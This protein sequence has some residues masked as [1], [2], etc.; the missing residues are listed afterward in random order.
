MY[1]LAVYLGTISFS[2]SSVRVA[3]YTLHESCCGQVNAW[4]DGLADQEPI[5]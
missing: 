2:L 3:F 5:S 4:R 1:C